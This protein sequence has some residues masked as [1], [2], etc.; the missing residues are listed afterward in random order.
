MRTCLVLSVKG[1]DFKKDQNIAL[2]NIQHAKMVLVGT[3][4]IVSART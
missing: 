1:F 2:L 4:A 3:N